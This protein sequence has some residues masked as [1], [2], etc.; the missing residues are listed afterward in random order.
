MN[1]FFLPPTTLLFRSSKMDLATKR[2]IKKV[3]L[4]LWLQ[5]FRHLPYTSVRKLAFSF[6]VI[7]PDKERSHDKVWGTIFRN[8]DWL[9]Q[10]TKKDLSVLVFGHDLK[11]IRSRTIFTRPRVFNLALF[12]QR[13]PRTN[14]HSWKDQADI[15]RFLID[16]L[17]GKENENDPCLWNIQYGKHTIR[18]RIPN[19]VHRVPEPETLFAV[20]EQGLR[21]IYLYWA[22]DRKQFRDLSPDSIVGVGDR[23]GF[24][25][26]TNY[27]KDVCAITFD[28]PTQ[29][30]RAGNF[31][32]QE[33][34][35]RDDDVYISFHEEQDVSGNYVWIRPY[36]RPSWM[37]ETEFRQL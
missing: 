8:Y 6:G 7:L 14:Q 21:S 31:H 4:E 35:R 18:L 34:L 26:T 22:N 28:P 30:P 32:W 9:E 27:I 1:D 16:S 20:G 10:L 23:A 25:L 33:L 3:S 29:L 24:R 13:T 2:P 36:H 12:Y 11:I 5:L 15:H 37:T 17:R 19:M